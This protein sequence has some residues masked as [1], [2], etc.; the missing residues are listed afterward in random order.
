M[1]RHCEETEGEDV[2][3]QVKERILE[4]ILFPGPSEETSSAISDPRVD[5]FQRLSFIVKFT[6]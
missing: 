3:L 4:E 1:E 6:P 2:H 5:G